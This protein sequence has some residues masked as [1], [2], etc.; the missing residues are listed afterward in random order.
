MRSPLLL[1]LHLHVRA[2]TWT[3][4]LADRLAQRRDERGSHNLEY[5]YLAGASL[6]FGLLIW[7]AMNGKLQDLLSKLA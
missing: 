2:A 4:A 6:A 5:A 3:G 7:G 1:L